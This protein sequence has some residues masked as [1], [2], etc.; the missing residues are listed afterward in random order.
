MRPELWAIPA[1]QEVAGVASRAADWLRQA[2]RDLEHARHDLESDYLEWAC[3]STHQAAEKAAKA[4]FQHLHGEARGHSV[5]GLLGALKGRIEIP[6]A[7]QEAAMRLDRLY[8]PT[9]YA[10]SFESG[11]PADYFG[12]KDAKEAIVDG[13]AIVD[14]CAS[15]ISR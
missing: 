10:S 5:T 13:A 8:I 1:D 11:T 14:F 12:K 4:L 7:L 2:Q 3:F 9:R 15:R 6:G